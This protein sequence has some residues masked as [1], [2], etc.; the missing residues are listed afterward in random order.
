MDYL[1]LLVQFWIKGEL[2]VW[3]DEIG[4][5]LEIVESVMKSDGRV[6]EDEDDEEVEICILDVVED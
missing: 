3:K 2:V 4:D 6:F 5:E 1:S